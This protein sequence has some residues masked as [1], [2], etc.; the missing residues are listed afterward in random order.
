MDTL[1]TD[2]DTGIDDFD[3]SA[4]AEAVNDIIFQ[5]DSHLAGAGMPNFGASSHQYRGANR[6]EMEEEV[7]PYESTL[8]GSH[9]DQN[10]RNLDDFESFFYMNT[11]FDHISAGKVL[12]ALS[13]DQDEVKIAGREQLQLE[14]G[15]EK[16][17]AV[18]PSSDIRSSTGTHDP[19]TTPSGLSEKD[20]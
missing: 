16:L 14:E 10:G 20:Q 13:T 15:A 9:G 5:L 12:P 17:P 8:G 1:D 4:W 18:T 6:S 11:P 7:N 2:A 19:T 3:D